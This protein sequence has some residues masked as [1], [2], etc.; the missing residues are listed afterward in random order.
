MV[1]IPL[2]YHQPTGA[3]LLF[4]KVHYGTRQSERN[5]PFVIDTGSAHTV[6]LP[7]D[8]AALKKDPKLAQVALAP[9]K[10]IDT[11]FGKLRYQEA[12]GV[13]LI[14]A[15]SEEGEFKIRLPALCFAHRRCSLYRRLSRVGRELKY[16][17]LGRDAM[18]RLTLYVDRFGLKE[19]K[20]GLRSMPVAF[21]TDGGDDIGEY[22][23]NTPP[24]PLPDYLTPQLPPMPAPGAIRW[25]H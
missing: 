4:A 2:G 13:S 12:S 3:L 6:M 11:L 21:L 1:I 17:I 14:A 10:H 25:L 24:G 8:Q 5:F 23:R 18:S 16:N 9:P 15:T 19:V 22:L 7:Y 20:Q